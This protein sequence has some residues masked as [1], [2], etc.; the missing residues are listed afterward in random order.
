MIITTIRFDFGTVEV[1]NNYVIMT[2]KEGVTVKPEYNKELERIAETYFPNQ[3]FAYITNRVH[4]YAVD[5]RVYLETSKIENLVAF[6]V[7]S[8]KPVNITNVEVEKIF[9][10]KPLET[11]TDM[12]EAISW[13]QDIIASQ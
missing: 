4:S 1:H 9:L 3:P 2:M 13:A 10:K 11:F 12:D 5:P 7:V 8:K 6:A